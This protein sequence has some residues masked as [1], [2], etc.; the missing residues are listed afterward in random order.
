MVNV[1]YRQ[2]EQS[3]STYS[4]WRFWHMG[5]VVIPIMI[6]I[7]QTETNIQKWTFLLIILNCS[8]CLER[9]LLQL[10]TEL[11]LIYIENEKKI[12]F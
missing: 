1:F 12:I 8:S 4:L 11:S 7:I 5:K 2:S 9:Y 6:F 3:Y 10:I